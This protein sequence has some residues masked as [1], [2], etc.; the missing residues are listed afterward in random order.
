MNMEK[1]TF[2]ILKDMESIYPSLY[3]LFNQNFVKVKGKKY[4]RIALESKTNSFSEVNDKFR[5]IIIVDEDRLPEQ[6]IPF[7]NR[8]EKQNLSFEYLMS[9]EQIRISHNLFL[10]C[11]NMIQYD[12]NKLRLINY[13]ID[14]LL[15]N[16]DEEEI[17]G[18]VFMEGQNIADTNNN[19]EEYYENKLISKISVTLPQDIIL[20][21]LFNNL[22]EENDEFV[23]FNNKIIKIYNQNLN[24]NIKSFL[25]NYK[26]DSNKIIIYTFT[27]IIDSIKKIIYP[28][29]K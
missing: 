25:T 6:E 29:L 14:N 2:L 10:K 8:F 21:L 19:N 9:K 23:K 13:N 7:L 5:C 27:R 3:D 4:A 11:Q 1:D 26:D 22:K 17:N 12:E 28:R 15:I 18:I 20:L 24:Y 16:C